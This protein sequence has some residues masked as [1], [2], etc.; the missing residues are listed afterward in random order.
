MG[1]YNSIIKGLEEAVKHE[2]GQLKG[3]KV[4]RVQIND[5]PRFE[6]SQIKL[7]RI[8][9]KLTQSSFSKVIGVSKKT[10][11]AWESGKN[12]PSGPAQRMLEVMSK[13]SA[14]L[15]KYEI[16]SK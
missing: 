16:I 11:E 7:I 13:D 10:V 14:F 2:R 15:E 3:A 1:T 5:L 4:K 6:S 8:S 9:N 12:I